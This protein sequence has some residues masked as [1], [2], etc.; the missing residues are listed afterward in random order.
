MNDGMAADG[1]LGRY[2]HVW[3][4]ADVFTFTP[5]LKEDTLVTMPLCSSWYHDNE[6]V[7]NLHDP[8]PFGPER[9]GSELTFA[10]RYGRL[11]DGTTSRPRTLWK[12]STAAG[13]VRAPST[14]SY[15]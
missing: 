8:Y 14:P 12:A 4:A 5:L 1:L 15:C 9:G 10:E 2:L 11:H 3:E 13:S 7:M 6:V